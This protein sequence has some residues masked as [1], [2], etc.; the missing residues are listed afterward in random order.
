MRWFA[1]GQLNV[2]YNCLD[3]HVKAGRG[4]T[5]AILFEGDEPGDV[6]RYT[7]SQ[8]LA[9]VCKVANVLT[10]HGVKK[11]DTGAWCA[12]GGSVQGWEGSR[13]ARLRHPRLCSRPPAVPP[14]P[15]PPHCPHPRRRAHVQWPCTC[16]WCRISRL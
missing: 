5:V 13:G 11:G 2:S 7:Y 16:P 8:V 9:E 10:Y 1:D 15:D 12:G 4:D 6:R 14:P 3:R